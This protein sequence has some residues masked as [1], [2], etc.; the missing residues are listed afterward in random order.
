MRAIRELLAPETALAYPAMRELRQVGDQAAFVQR[1]DDVQRPEGY[2][3]AGAF[4]PGRDHAVAVAG[5]RL[6]HNLA[7]G[8]TLYVDDL[9]TLPAGRRHGHARA[10]LRWLAEEARRLDCAELHLDSAV[11]AARFDAHRVYLSAGLD[12]T[13]HHFS[14]PVEAL[15]RER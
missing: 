10:L 4:E 8:A 11:G 12:I 2:R 7:F 5:F 14:A 13:S 9:S 1:V 15:L 6:V 3:L